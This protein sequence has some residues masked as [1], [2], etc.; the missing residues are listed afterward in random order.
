[1]LPR[2]RMPCTA[3]RQQDFEDAWSRYVPPPV[4]SQDRAKQSLKIGGKTSL[5]NLFHERRGESHLGQE[6]ALRWHARP[7]LLIQ[8]KNSAADRFGR[9][10]AAIPL[11]AR[12]VRATSWLRLSLPMFTPIGWSMAFWRW[13]A[14]ERSS[15]QPTCASLL[16]CCRSTSRYPMMSGC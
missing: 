7:S 5:A 6:E 15:P 16:P 14:C 8:R 2:H 4:S 1:M 9:A 12:R 3:Y 13:C 11:V 10:K